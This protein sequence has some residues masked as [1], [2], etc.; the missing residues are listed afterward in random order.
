MDTND[1]LL[2]IKEVAEYLGVP[3]TTLY[4]WRY[5]RKGPPSVRI[6]RHVRYR[7]TDLF[8]WVEQELRAGDDR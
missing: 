3:I 5:N 2:T 1:R 6:G 7:P 4:Q 8:G